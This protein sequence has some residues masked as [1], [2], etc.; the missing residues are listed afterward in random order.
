[1]KLGL[2]ATVLLALAA[3]ACGPKLAT[4]P[5][6]AK[7][8]GSGYS[9]RATTAHGV[10]IAAR[11]ESNAPEASLDFWV[12]AV[13]LRLKHDGYVPEDDRPLKTDLGLEGRELRYTRD[14]SGRTT[15]YW[16]GIF[17]TPKRVYLVEAG[18]DK[19]DFDPAVPA[20]ETALR[21]LDAN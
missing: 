1:M 9:Y 18:G 10:V 16:L 15:R 6:F 17:T 12:H 11:S 7:V 21:S 19:A 5:S 13:D 2:F 3:T 4:P 8:N 14:D 20:I